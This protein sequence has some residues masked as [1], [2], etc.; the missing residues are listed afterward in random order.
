[1]S[2]EI[3]ICTLFCHTLHG[4]CFEISTVLTSSYRKIIRPIRLA[5]TDAAMWNS[6]NFTIDLKYT[7]IICI[8]IKTD[9]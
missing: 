7:Y 2:A 8:S 1:M 5:G 9:R 4:G 3:D 6:F